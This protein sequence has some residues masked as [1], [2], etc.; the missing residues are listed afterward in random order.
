MNRLEP[1]QQ[2]LLCTLLFFCTGLVLAACSSGAVKGES[3]FA[4]VS[5]WQLDGS[6]LSLELRLRNVNDE[7]LQFSSVTLNVLIEDNVPLAKIQR[8]VALSIP[9][10]GFETIRLQA[11]ASSAGVVLLDAL[12]GEDSVAY[13]LEGAVDSSDDGLLRFMH[14]GRIYT[15]PGRPG[16]FR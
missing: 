15:V 7:P 13:Q 2:R 6:T 12:T 8:E 4:Q 11:T 1:A 16:E 3:P 10:G 9:A 14:A 5:S